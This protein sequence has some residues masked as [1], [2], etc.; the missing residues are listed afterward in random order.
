M[1]AK[2]FPNCDSA[3]IAKQ[4]DAYHKD[5]PAGPQ[6]TDETPMRTDPG[7]RGKMLDSIDGQMAAKIDAEVSSSVDAASGV[8]AAPF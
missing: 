2:A 4:L 5:D 6:V 7:A 3:C 8:G 1:H